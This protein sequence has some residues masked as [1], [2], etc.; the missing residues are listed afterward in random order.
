[1]HRVFKTFYL[2]IKNFIYKAF[3]TT[4]IFL[5]IF[6]FKGISQVIIELE[7]EC[8]YTKDTISLYVNVKTVSEKPVRIIKPVISLPLYL[9]KGTWLLNFIY[10]DS[11]IMV[12]PSSYMHDYTLSNKD[13]IKISK[14]DSLFFKT[15]VE[16]NYLQI[17]AKTIEEYNYFKK[18]PNI[19]Y[20][21]Y[22]I[23]V[24]YQQLVRFGK[25]KQLKSNEV[26]VIYKKQ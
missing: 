1:M 11:I 3:L 2:H 25:N 19:N 20:G 9:N 6:N 10:N 4:L 15:N 22:R 24:T 16:M 7:K 18:E 23:Y 14:T 17:P 26:E 5:C 12:F 13:Y 8:E 21:V